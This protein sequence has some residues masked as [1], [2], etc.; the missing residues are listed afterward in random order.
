MHIFVDKLKTKLRYRLSADSRATRIVFLILAVRS[1]LFPKN[2]KWVKIWLELSE[3]SHTPTG[4][5]AVSWQGLLY[6]VSNHTVRT[7]LSTQTSF[8]L[9]FFVIVGHATKVKIN[10]LIRSMGPISEEDMV[11][12]FSS[13]IF[14]HFMTHWSNN[15][16]NSSQAFKSKV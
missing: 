14:R 6:P 5:L 8:L 2:A 3:K 4:R 9:Y 15:K 11:C 16:A 10:I 12:M 1:T 7:Y 13:P